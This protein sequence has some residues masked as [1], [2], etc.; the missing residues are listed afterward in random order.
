MAKDI[1]DLIEDINNVLEGMGGWDA[2]CTK[3]LS[4]GIAGLAA[5]RFDPSAHEPRDSIGMSSLGKPCKRQLW[6]KVNFPA[7]GAGLP[8][9][10]LGTFFYGD[11]LE[12]VVLALAIAAGHKVEGMQDRLEIN[13]IR[14]HRDAVIDGMTVDVKSASTFSFMKFQSGKLRS[15]DPFGYISQLSSYVYAGKDDPLVTDKK[16]GAFLVINKDRFKLCLD[17]HNFEEELKGKEKEVEE[18]KKVVKSA[19][20]PPRAFEDK[21]DGYWNTKKKFIKNGNR[22]LDTQCSYCEYKKLCWPGLRTFIQSEGT[23][24]EKE[25][26]FTKVVKLPKIRELKE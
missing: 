12:V 5:E 3:F 4:E 22:V 1:R 23:V 7:K 14:G 9:E 15:N 13:G 8:A 19:K 6:Y 20:P 18:V 24:H 17:I 26:Y 11:I 10:T 25:K 2:A 21:E 16:R